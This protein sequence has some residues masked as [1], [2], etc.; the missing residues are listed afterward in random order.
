[1]S[2][3][4]G[5]PS[6]TLRRS[7]VFGVIV[8]SCLSL[9]ISDYLVGM[10]APIQAAATRAAAEN[11]IL[12]DICGAAD[13]EQGAG[14]ESVVKS[15]YGLVKVPWLVVT[16]TE[17]KDDQGKPTKKPVA[18]IGWVSV[19]VAQFGQC[20]YIFV[21]VWFLFTG[22]PRHDSRRWHLLPLVLSILAALATVYYIYIMAAKLEHWCRLCLIL[23]VADFLLLMLI[24]ALWPWAPALPK[25]SRAERLSREAEAS[26]T[27]GLHPGH[28]LACLACAAALMATSFIHRQDQMLAGTALARLGLSERIWAKA[29]KD[30]R[31]VVGALGATRQ[32][33][34]TPRS[35]QMTLGKPD[36]PHELV[37][38]SDLQCPACRGFEAKLRKEILPLWNDRL[39]VTY[40]H[41]PLC[42]DC[43]PGSK[44]HHPQACN[45]AYAVEAARVVGGPT[46]FWK[47]HDTIIEQHK[48]LAKPDFGPEG[49]A[50]FA[51][52]M[53]LDAAKF[54]QA[55]D[56]PEVRQI[57]ADDIELAK[58]LGVTGT[59]TVY[60]DGRRL[61]SYPLQTNNIHFWKQLARLRTGS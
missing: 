40:R 7:A 21:L 60:L 58:S 56:S 30:V 42:R 18:K 20:Y 8:L 6:K 34:I 12:A 47:M 43:L 9:W 57:V 33:T 50:K 45:A 53:G 15:E 29:Q 48:E 36:A 49:F 41:Y 25:G 46:A 54:G 23:H 38:F 3:V 5:L 37:M 4:M 55:F 32:V 39:K 52:Q 14:C 59:P 13:E 24:A 11:S 26:S 1:M 61:L 28:A 17:T 27:T 16:L 44:I 51:Q 2:K 22:L 19:P 31:F 10:H 35:T